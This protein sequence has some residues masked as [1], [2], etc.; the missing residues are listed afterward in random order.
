MSALDA[1]IRRLAREEAAALTGADPD[2]TP[3]AADT[4]LAQLRQQVEELTARV[5]A[6]EKAPRQARTARKETG[7]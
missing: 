6:L 4:E 2:A 7:A 1:R 3:A 5:E